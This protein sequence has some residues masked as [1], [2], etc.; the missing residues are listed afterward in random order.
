[1]INL[2]S[3][4]V[5]G[6][7]DLD[8][9]DLPDSVVQVQNYSRD[10]S[11]PPYDDSPN[12]WFQSIPFFNCLNWS[13]QLHMAAKQLG[14]WSLDQKPDLVLLISH[15]VQSHTKICLWL[16]IGVTWQNILY[17][18]RA[19]KWFP[20]SSDLWQSRSN[21]GGDGQRLS[22][23]ARLGASLYQFCWTPWLLCFC[24]QWKDFCVSATM[25]EEVTTD[26]GEVLQ[27][28][29]VKVAKIFKVLVLFKDAPTF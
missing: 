13:L 14:D 10:S 27:K 15:Q 6:L 7:L 4:F 2:G 24:F 16:K 1:M 22:T 23:D 9:P 29:V 25:G 11:T 21:L 20:G 3:T 18:D 26:L 19:E 8:M 12:H 5:L 28:I 17:D